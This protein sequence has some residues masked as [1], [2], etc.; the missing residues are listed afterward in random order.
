MTAQVDA[1]GS[2]GNGQ[3]EQIIRCR[4]GA[5]E[6]DHPVDIKF[7][8]GCIADIALHSTG[9][10]QEHPTSQHAQTRYL[11]ANNRLLAPSLCH[12]HV[13]LDKAFILG[14]PKYSHLRVKDGTFDEAMKQ[15]SEAKKMFELEDLLTRGRRLMKESIRAGVSHMRAFVEV[16]EIVGLKCLEAGTTLKQEFADRCHVQLCAFAQ[17]PLKPNDPAGDKIR[18]LMM[19]ALLPEHHV[20]A[21]GS[22]P[23]VETDVNGQQANIEWLV[24][25]AVKYD[26]HL[27]F[28]LDYSV[29][30]GSPAMVHHLLQVLKDR[31]WTSKSNK[32]I[33]LGHCTRLIFYSDK[34]IHQLRTEIGDLPVSFVGLPTSDLYMMKT[35]PS[36]RLHQSELR[37]TLNVPKLIKDF[38][39]NAAIGIN[40]IGN[41]FTPY[42]SCDPLFLASIATGIYQTGTEQDARLLYECVSSRAK[43]AIGLGDKADRS[44]YTCTLQHGDEANFVLFPAA[45]GDFGSEQS[46]EGQIYYYNQDGRQVF[47]RGQLITQIDPLH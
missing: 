14:H 32:C 28:H 29:D 24:D 46:I 43:A 16:D 5:S 9:T 11:D 20:D 2:G 44:S 4:L 19:Q 40:N 37:T 39:I 34:D 7:E 17:L 42:G 18:Q 3:I 36:L 22:T 38:G 47:Y 1:D 35:D 27:D 13:H 25:L 15:T 30:Q 8:A 33:T 23:Y 45:P 26:K 41:A 21:I 10:S 31:D 6:G 12:P